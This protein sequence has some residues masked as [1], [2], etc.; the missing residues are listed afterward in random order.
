MRLARTLS[1]YIL[2]E[3]LQYTV[4]GLAAITIVFVSRGLLRFLDELMVI[5]FEP[6]I[7]AALLRC[8]TATLIGYT[9]PIAFLFG[10][11]LAV[12]RLASNREINAMRACGL[13]LREIMLPVLVL[14]VSISCI[15][16]YLAIDVEYSAQRQL[17][18]LIKQMAALGAKL[19]P[20]RFRRIGERV[21][22]IGSLSP[23]NHMKGIVISDRSDPDRHLMIFA[24]YGRLDLD[25]EG[26]EL[27]FRLTNGGVHIEPAEGSE[28]RYQRISFVDF[29]YAFET[30]RVFGLDPSR[31]RPA[32]MSMRELRRIAARARAGES[33]EGVREKDPTEYELQIHRR[34][35]LPV[36]PI[37]FGLVGVPL[38][39][40]G[41]RGAR[42]WGALLCAALAFVYYLI[43]SFSQFLALSGI[44]P[45]AVALWVP[46]AVFGLA[47]AA[48]LRTAR[49]AEL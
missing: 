33:L 12:G 41:G 18:V 34:I 23:D 11:L 24:E 6:R 32:E 7:A 17:R 19:E 44:L 13:G 1:L 40:R 39:L 27:H 46:N 10:V 8:T 15:T 14:A 5:G 9:I 36:A 28:D 26:G 47:A 35:A 29:D 43:L 16:S 37:L 20:G 22:F 49:R 4:L 3:V 42:S 21:F 48:L 2:R 38:A 31:V 45:A 25:V 30:D